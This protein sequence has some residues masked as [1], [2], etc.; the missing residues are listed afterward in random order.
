[1]RRANKLHAAYTLILGEEELASGKAQLKNMS[2]GSQSQVDLV[3]L[4][5]ILLQRLQ[6]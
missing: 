5:D 1:M 2:D 4:A 3:G 6:G